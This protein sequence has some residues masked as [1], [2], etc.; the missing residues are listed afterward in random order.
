MSLM[1]RMYRMIL[2]I[3]THRRQLRDCSEART[4]E[5]ALWIRLNN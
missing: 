2:K 3:L 5:E 4:K 1:G